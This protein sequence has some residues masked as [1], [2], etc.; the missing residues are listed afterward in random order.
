M[1]PAT[2]FGAHAVE[3]VDIRKSAQI[4]AGIIGSLLFPSGELFSVLTVCGVITI[5]VLRGPASGLTAGAMIGFVFLTY[6]FLEPI[7]EFTEVLDQTQTA[8]AG[9]RRVLGRARHGNGTRLDRSAGAASAG[10]ASTSSFA[11]SPSPTRPEASRRRSTRR[12]CA[13]ST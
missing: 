2:K 12:C 9:L 4:R 6:R 10:R 5:G 11:T 3:A 7:A 8:V 13:M 1:T